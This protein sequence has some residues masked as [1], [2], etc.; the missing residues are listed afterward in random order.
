MRTPGK[1]NRASPNGA[2][3]PRVLMRKH[4]ALRAF[5]RFRVHR[6]ALA[7]VLVLHCALWVAPGL[8]AEA[9][10]AS[11][12]DSF[13]RRVLELYQAGKYQEAILIARQLLE[14]P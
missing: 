3:R 6:N 8:A 2:G 7:I 5:S 1:S 11:E 13:N 10:D 14:I 4:L 9:A 12:A